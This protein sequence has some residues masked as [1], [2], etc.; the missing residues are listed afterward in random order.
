MDFDAMASDL[1]A[2]FAL[3]A[4]DVLDGARAWT[5]QSIES[6]AKSLSGLIELADTPMDIPFIGAI[7][8]WITGDDLTIL[9]AVCFLI[10]FPVHVVYFVVTRGSR[11]SD[12]AQNWF[13][14]LPSAGPP[15]KRTSTL[16]SA[17]GAPA[18]LG[19]LAISADDSK[20]K[21]IFY[22]VMK[23]VHIL[24]VVGT[25]ASFRNVKPSLRAWLKIGRGLAGCLTTWW[26][27]SS[28]R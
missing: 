16:V 24:F 6:L 13:P 5:I 11:F 7:Y 20:G 12:D 15:L 10:G 27:S 4:E 23:A 19:A 28:S 22:V 2:L 17:E 26:T 21:E 18:G 1:K 9:S 8:K 3:L 14:S 25:D